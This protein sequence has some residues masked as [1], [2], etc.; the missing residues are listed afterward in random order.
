MGSIHVAIWRLSDK[1]FKRLY[2]KKKETF[3][4]FFIEFLKCAWNLEHSAKKEGYLSL[5]ITEI[6]ASE[7]DVY[8]SVQKVLL[9][10]T[11]R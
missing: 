2:L 4:R 7:R 6:Y 11:I 10:H 3:F 8:S 1:E 9:Q 5:I